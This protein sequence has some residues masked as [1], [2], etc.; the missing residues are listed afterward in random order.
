MSHELYLN[1]TLVDPVSAPLLVKSPCLAVNEKP[2][3]T[4]FLYT[5]LNGDGVGN[6]LLKKIGDMSLFVC[7]MECPVQSFDNKIHR[8]LWT[9]YT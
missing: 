3:S 7:H 5:F 6:I 1:H 2:L 8:K 9:F 4:P